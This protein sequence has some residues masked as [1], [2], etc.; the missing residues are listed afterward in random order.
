MTTTG[1]DAEKIG[2]LVGQVGSNSIIKSCYAKGSITSAG[3][4]SIGGLVGS[5]NGEVVIS[6][7]SVSVT[8]TNAL[9][10][11]G[12]VGKNNATVIACYAIGAVSGND[13]VG[14]L[15][16]YIDSNGRVR[17]CYSVGN[18]TSDNGG[19]GLYGDESF[20]PDPQYSY[21]DDD[22]TVTATSKEGEEFARPASELKEPTDY[23]DI[24]EDWN[25]DVDGDNSED[26]SLGLWF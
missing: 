6:Y 22:A 5:N 16:G 3:I 8:A 15:I 12:L 4:R 20:S 1:F 7:A 13:G 21:Y 14:G 10:V 9:H 17:A 23:T 11:G 2:G 19:G 24:Y 18:V 26:N 25:V